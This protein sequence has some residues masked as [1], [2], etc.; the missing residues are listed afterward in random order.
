M[1][2]AKGY[3]YDAFFQN[4]QE[5]LEK[6]Y[7]YTSY[8]CQHKRRGPIPGQLSVRAAGTI[9]TSYHVPRQPEQQ[10]GHTGFLVSRSLTLPAAPPEE[11]QALFEDFAST[12]KWK[13]NYN[14]RTSNS[15]AVSTTL[16]KIRAAIL[17]QFQHI[18]RRSQILLLQFVVFLWI[19]SRERRTRREYNAPFNYER[20]FLCKLF[21]VDCV[22]VCVFVCFISRCLVS[23]W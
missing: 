14:K 16:H 12:R 7:T 21:R 20:I 17:Q 8:F 6:K 2:N 11:P 18:E 10:K 1:H 3:E 4:T 22:C 19:S 23:V 13:K 15:S 9:Q 5:L